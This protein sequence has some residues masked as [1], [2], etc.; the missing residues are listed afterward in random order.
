[1]SGGHRTKSPS[2]AS[3]AARTDKVYAE[4]L[5]AAVE[6]SVRPVPKVVPAV[7]AVIM[8]AIV[9]ALLWSWFSY[10]DVFTNA[11][12]RVR[13]SVPPAVV[14]PLEGGR[15][16]AIKVE[17]GQKVEA[18]QELLLLDDVDVRASLDAAISSRLSWLAEVERRRAALTHA[19]EANWQLPVPQFDAEIPEDVVKREM[20]ALR[21]EFLTVAASVAALNAQR[22]EVEAKRVRFETVIAAQKRLV[23]ILAEKASMSEAL[24]STAA[25]SKV[26]VLTAK[27]AKARADADLAESSAGL[28]ETQAALLNIEEQQ[29]QTV[30]SFIAQQSLGIQ[31]AEREIEQ[32]DQEIIKQHNRLAHLALRAPIAGAVQQLATTSAGQVVAAGQTMLVIVAD[33]AELIVEALV[34]SSEIGFVHAGDKVTIKADAFPFTRYGAFE[35]R[36]ASISSDAVTIQNAQ[37]LQ[38]PSATAT[39]QANATPTGIPDVV[40]LF[41]VARIALDNPAIEVNGAQ[42]TLEPGMTVRAEIKTESRRVIDYILSPVTEV[43]EEAGHER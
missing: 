42:L 24:L 7:M 39:G 16:I 41:Y 38:D 2:L 6:I 43:L 13:A 26:A 34:S 15:I 23:D 27:E 32:L 25:G 10:L 12:G 35:G 5:P 11:A 28:R 4:F 18:G 36:V 3:D 17:N 40:G 1:M 14:Q 30:A 29:R 33:D 21:G 37:A 20:A 31:A 19:Q 22:Q 9:A 8:A